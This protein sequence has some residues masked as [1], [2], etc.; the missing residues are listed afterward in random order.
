MKIC[1]L[2]KLE[3]ESCCFYKNATTKDKL[4]SYCKTCHNQKTKNKYIEN[5]EVRR[6]Q[7]SSY[8]YS[9][10]ETEKEAR[11]NH[12]RKNKEKYLLA[13][14]KRQSKIKQATPV[15]L[16]EIETCEILK[17]YS[18]SAYLSETTGIKH[19]VDHIVPLQGKNVCGLNV[20]WN[21]QVLTASDNLKKSNKHE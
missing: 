1:K 7:L 5:Y 10:H 8:Y 3:K 9:N 6:K 19:H 17:F 2:C 13:F 4:H 20:P 11:R 21:L 14:Y 16:T 18:D 15:W 12:Y